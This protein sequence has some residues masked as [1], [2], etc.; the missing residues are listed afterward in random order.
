MRLLRR[1]SRGSVGRFVAGAIC[2]VIKSLL[3]RKGA[4]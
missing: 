2:K 1:N 4:Y 3:V